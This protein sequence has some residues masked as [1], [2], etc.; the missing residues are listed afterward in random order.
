[1]PFH[2]LSHCPVCGGRETDCIGGSGEECHHCGMDVDDFVLDSQSTRQLHQADADP[3][4]AV[5]PA[6]DEE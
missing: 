2:T 6:I 1:M 3:R 5:D 4:L